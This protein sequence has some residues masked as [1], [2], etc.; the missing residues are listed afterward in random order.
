MKQK[1][2]LK[3]LLPIVA[4]AAAGAIGLGIFQTAGQQN[5][6]PVNVYPFEYI[7]MTEYWADSQESYGPVQTDKVQTV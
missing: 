4:V 6:E 3:I 7:G 2:W 1:K 5:G